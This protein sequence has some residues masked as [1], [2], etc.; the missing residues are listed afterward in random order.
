K[1]GPAT[2]SPGDHITYTLDFQN[3][4][5][6][7]DSDDASGAQ[8]TDTLPGSVAF[9]SASGAPGTVDVVGNQVI[10]D[11]GIVANGAS[12]SRT[13]TV[14][15]NAAPGSILVNTATILS[16]E[17]DENPADNTSTFTTTV[18]QSCVA[19]SIVTPPAAAEVCEGGSVNFS[20][21]ASGSE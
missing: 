11:L 12:G 7:G 1:S 4:N 6:G 14:I 5:T 19:P 18:G 13:L 9:D 20:V 8:I 21:T 3:L 17:N 10:W 15:V 16:A 2:A